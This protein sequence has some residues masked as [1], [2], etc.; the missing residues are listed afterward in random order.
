MSIAS[1]S[2]RI[3]TENT[4]STDDIDSNGQKNNMYSAEYQ[5]DGD[6]SIQ[7]LT[8]FSSVSP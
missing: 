2:E 5:T 1:F 4:E 6:R 7:L 3:H 8:S